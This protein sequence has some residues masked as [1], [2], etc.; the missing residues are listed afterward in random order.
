MAMTASTTFATRLLL[1]P[2]NRLLTDSVGS[3]WSRSN[4]ANDPK[5]LRMAALTSSGW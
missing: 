2:R 1:K 3:P 4:F 5:R